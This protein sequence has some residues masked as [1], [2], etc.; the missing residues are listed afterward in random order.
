MSYL[1]KDYMSKEVPTVDE[2]TLI[3]EAAQAISKPGIL[4][5]L[6][7]GKPIGIV[8]E[9]DFVKKILAPEVDPK[10]ISVGEIMS[11]PIVSIDPDENLIKA[12]EVMQKKN[13]R[14]LPVIKDG[15]IYGVIT[16]QTIAIEC[17]KYVD[18]SV[19]DI[20]KWIPFFYL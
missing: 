15:I 18:Q 9:Y 4:I 3:P 13:I 12:P 6:R 19:K 5:V 11:T 7:K 20:M 10:H 14:R 2:H 8:T 1:V 17:R 16:V